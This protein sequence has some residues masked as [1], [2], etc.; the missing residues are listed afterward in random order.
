MVLF[1]GESTSGLVTGQPM[2]GPG[3]PAQVAF[4]ELLWLL[5]VLDSRVEQPREQPYSL[6]HSF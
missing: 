3:G 1:L 6:K 5:L 2:S 4:P